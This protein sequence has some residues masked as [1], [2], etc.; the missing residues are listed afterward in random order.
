MCPAVS[1][2]R[3]VMP[4]SPEDGFAQSSDH[5]FQANSA[6]C[7]IVDA[8]RQPG[9]TVDLNF[10]SCDGCAPGSSNNAILAIRT[11]HFA[12]AD[13]SCARPTDVSVHTVC[14]SRCCSRIVT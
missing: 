6:F 2:A 13:L 5:S 11:G 3:E 7:A 10:N 9:A 14:P 12:G 8:G 1:I 4:C